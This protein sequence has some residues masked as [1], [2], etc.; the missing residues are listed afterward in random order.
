M[1]VVAQNKDPDRQCWQTA[2]K[3]QF[4]SLLQ[5][6]IDESLKIVVLLFTQY[7]YSIVSLFKSE[8]LRNFVLVV[9]IHA[10]TSVP[11]ACNY[12]TDKFNC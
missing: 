2:G 11:N 7:S 5:A 10:I 3:I 4:Y 8:V 6:R 9:I 12:W 1:F